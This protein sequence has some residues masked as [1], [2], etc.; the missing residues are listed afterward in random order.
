MKSSVALA[1]PCPATATVGPSHGEPFGASLVNTYAGVH[2]LGVAAPLLS[3]Y[4]VR[5]VA[6]CDGNASAATALAATNPMT[7][8]V[9]FMA[10]SSPVEMPAVDFDAGGACPAAVQLRCHAADNRVRAAYA[11]AAVSS[12]PAA[13]AS[14]GAGSVP[15]PPRRLICISVDSSRPAPASASAKASWRCSSSWLAK[16][17]LALGTGFGLGLGLG[18]GLP[19]AGGADASAAGG[20]ITAAGGTGFV[21][22]SG[23]SASQ[24]TLADELTSAPVPSDAERPRW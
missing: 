13:P 20:A 15:S 12:T 4:S 9:C 11:V 16:P 14:Q 5:L 6:A 24:V 21:C 22:G 10:R 18:S 8:R 17:T 2:P 19:G 7:G 3:K 23:A 1:G